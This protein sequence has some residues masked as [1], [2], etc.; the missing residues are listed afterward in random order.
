LS[1]TALV[2]EVPE[3][4]EIYDRWVDLWD[5]PPG[6]PV[7]VTL[8]IP[9]G[10]VDVFS[11][12]LRDL[13]GAAAAFSF[14]L[15]RIERFPETTWLAPEPAEPFVALTEALFERFPDYPPYGGIHD[16]I[17]PHLTIV[18][19]AEPAVLDR[20]E[21]ELAPLLPIEGRAEEVLALEK[22]P[23]G[24]WHRGETFRLGT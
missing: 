14:R 12:E 9:F 8:L 15:E 24:I 4:Q 23:D 22:G 17:V 3:A 6:A 11:D 2:V 20:A 7:H 21:A 1:E 16:E 19:R 18:S 13:F 10:P 5:P